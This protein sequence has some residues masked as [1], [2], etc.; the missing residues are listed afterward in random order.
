MLDITS[1]LML[2]GSGCYSKILA[3]VYI[4]YLLHSTYND[5]MYC[6]QVRYVLGWGLRAKKWPKGPFASNKTA[7]VN[8]CQTTD[9]A[10]SYSYLSKVAQFFKSYPE[11]DLL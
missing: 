10:A 8:H 1:S 3:W 7:K 5:F 6:R 9:M 11:Q 4:S 2:N